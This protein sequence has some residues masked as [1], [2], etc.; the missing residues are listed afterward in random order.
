MTL[1]RTTG[2]AARC[3]AELKK[4]VEE[5]YWRAGEHRSA[6]R[7]LSEAQA[8][9]PDANLNAESAPAVL[10]RVR[11]E[12]TEVEKGR[13]TLE[14]ALSHLE[15]RRR[16][17]GEAMHA[18]NTLTGDNIDP[19]H[20]HAAPAR[21]SDGCANSKQ[22]PTRSIVSQKRPG[23]RLD[24]DNLGVLF[25]LCQNLDL[26]LLIA[27]PEVAQAVGNTTY[28]LVRKPDAQGREDVIATGRRAQ[29]CAVRSCLSVEQRAYPMRMV[30]MG[31]LYGKGPLME[32]NIVPSF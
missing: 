17:H 1:C 28:R 25:N 10:D 27:A 23:N 15:I 11:A 29:R 16:E 26:Q 13:S 32:N 12:R 3:L 7:S 20:A 2:Y 24:R 21:R 19:D 18:L 6:I 31:Q 30:S 4:G 8:A 5:L 22:R 9:L 14:A